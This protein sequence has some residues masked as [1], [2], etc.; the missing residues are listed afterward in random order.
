VGCAIGSGSEAALATSDAALLGNDLYG[1]PAAVAVAGSTY[2]IIVQNF[3]WAMGYNVAA[4]PLAATGLLDPLVAAV[5]MGLSSVLVVFNSLR[6]VRLGRNGIEHVRPPRLHGGRGV[7]AS[8]LL[9][10]VL[11]AGL[12]AISQAVSP[13]R[14]QS[15]L[16]TLPSLEV[17]NLPA[18]GSVES[19]FDPGG[20]G[21]NQLHL[22]FSGTPRQVASVEPVVS[23]SLDGGPAQRLR[24]LKVG[25]GH[26][27][28]IVV[29]TP[30]TWHVSVAT[31][32]GRTPVT[33]TIE[34]SVH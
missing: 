23:A 13:A 14:G 12:V 17:R 2:A 11:F 33:F 8:V 9:P 24:Q 29:L 3:G 1:V 18:G 4:L 7:V 21:V 28:E 5:A 6:L 19:Y 15:L 31:P 26:F 32:F 27:S 10:I 25:P 16:P 22:I 30:G 20:V 34:Q